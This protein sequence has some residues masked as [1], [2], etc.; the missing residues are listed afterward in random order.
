MDVL[1]ANSGAGL[2]CLVKQLLLFNCHWVVAPLLTMSLKDSMGGVAGGWPSGTSTSTFNRCLMSAICSSSRAL[3]RSLGSH[4]PITASTDG[5]DLRAEP[6]E[7]ILLALGVLGKLGRR[8]APE[9]LPHLLPLPLSKLLRL[10]CEEDLAPELKLLLL[11][12][13]L[14]PLR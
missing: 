14:W 6:L 10:S 3:T 12:S 2:Q 13:A 5:N 1:E 4:F 11:P 8:G 9:S 7:S